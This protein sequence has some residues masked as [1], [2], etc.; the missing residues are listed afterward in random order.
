VVIDTSAIVSIFANEPRRGELVEAITMADQRLM[1][2]VNYYET[3]IV[4][5][6]RFG[7]EVHADFD[8]WLD[9]SRI[10]IIP[11]TRK[12]AQ[13]ARQAYRRFGKG[14]NAAKLNLADCAAYALA[15]ER[16]D[17]LL[18]VGEDFLKTDVRPYAPG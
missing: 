5:L 12:Q 11:F 15:T 4:L 13:L 9:E 8:L 1:S 14:I 2:A 7:A 18:F 3:N 10:E 16:D 6:L 17:A